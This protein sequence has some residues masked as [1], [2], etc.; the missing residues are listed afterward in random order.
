MG[1][2]SPW[3]GLHAQA[4]EGKLTFHPQA[5]IDAAEAVNKAATGLQQIVGNLNQLELQGDPFGV[6]PDAKMAVF[7]HS[8]SHRMTERFREQARLLAPVIDKHL[9]TL[10]TMLE[11]F[12]VAGAK[13]VDA[14]GSQNKRFKQLRDGFPDKKISKL[15]VSDKDWHAIEAAEKRRGSKGKD[16]STGNVS[17]DAGESE[18]PI[19]AF[20]YYAALSAYPSASATWNDLNSLYETMKPRHVGQV[21]SWWL[22][23]AQKAREVDEGLGADLAKAFRNWQSDGATAALTAAAKY[24]AGLV[25]LGQSMNLTGRVLANSEG[26]LATTQSYLPKVDAATAAPNGYPHQ[27]QAKLEKQLTK[28]RHHYQA[29]YVKEFE[30]ASK[31]VPKVP[32]L[33][34]ALPGDPQF[35]WQQPDKDGGPKVNPGA[36]DTKGN[37]PGT[38]D[39]KGDTPGTGDTK[40]GQN[41]N[42]QNGNGQNGTGQQ[43]TGQELL[44]MV[45][46]LL[47]TAGQV[48]QQIGMAAQTMHQP[49]L[50]QPG[51]PDQGKSRPQAGDPTERK[52]GGGGG[53][54]GDGAAKAA[55]PDH[56]RT[57]PAKLF[58]RAGA[59]AETDTAA[60]QP[61]DPGQVVAGAP[62]TP[63]MGAMPPGV[64]SPGQQGAEHKRPQFLAS[65]ENLHE[66]LGDDQTTYRP[67]VDR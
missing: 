59:P 37:T 2:E 28:Y 33:T 43:G 23:L 40:A 19:D 9:T 60:A 6:I 4:K 54:G 20:E 44:G 13:Y 47:Q 34:F 25:E 36:G 42:G 24:R 30:P 32:G 17:S 12:L 61:R 63:G 57:Y 53:G 65:T 46:T 1:T 67:V 31:H 50:G 51:G 62:G 64:H 22:R 35:P 15:K 29:H 18:K 8:A 16:V 21:G 11:T 48:V 3:T 14:D 7:K 58:P 55:G 66:V 41:G 52:G 49:T 10:R 56:T 45:S 38:G 39:T 5:A 27:R 26:W